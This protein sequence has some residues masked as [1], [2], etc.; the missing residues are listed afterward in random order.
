MN[1][2]IKGLSLFI[3]F[4]IGC[5]DIKN[6]NENDE[7][8]L[9]KL[10][11][12][13]PATGLDG[14]DD[15]GLVDLEYETGLELFGL[16]RILGDTLNY[17][18]GYRVRYGRRILNR[19]RTVDF[20]IEGDSAL[21]V[22]SYNLNGT[23]VVQVRDTFT[24]DVVDSMGFSK[25]F[26]SLMTRKVKFVRTVNQNN[27][28]G[29][30][31]RI[32]AMTPLVGFS[33]DKVSLSYLNIFSVNASTDSIN[34]ITVEEGNMLFALNSSE[35]GNLFLDRD[36]LPTFDAF[37]HIMLKIAVENNGPDEYALDSVGVGEWV[38]NRYGRSQYQRGR[39]KL[40]DMGIGVDEIV[41]D[42]IH[43][44]LWRIHGPGLGQESR[45]F[46]SF[47]SIIDLGSEYLQLA[48]LMLKL[49]SRT[50]ILD[51]GSSKF[52]SL[53]LQGL[54]FKFLL[55]IFSLI[56]SPISYLVIGEG[57]AI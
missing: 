1:F 30:F 50:F 5:S 4:F 40:N 14:F 52:R 18:E 20:S 12:E 51:L 16:S 42:N 39:R 31:W 21:G 29:Y 28:D 26:S 57:L 8:V 54:K 25:D 38:M 47:F 56:R 43:A 46:R 55:L 22:I 2:L 49:V 17:G 11:D 9:L 37:Q 33:G 19:D 41:N 24:M 48:F 10:L 36:N 6:N 34:G 45:I 35:I 3:I 44:G 23:F 15:G 32:S 7:I 27:P 13:D 53:N